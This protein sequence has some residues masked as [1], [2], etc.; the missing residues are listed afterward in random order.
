MATRWGVQRQVCLAYSQAWWWESHCLGLHECCR[1]WELQFIEGTMNANMYCDVL[2]QSMIPSLQRLCRRAVFQHDNDPKHTSKMTTTLLKKLR[3]KVILK[4]KV[5][6]RKV[7]SIH[8]LSDVV[9]EEWKRTPVVT[10]ETLVNSMPKRVKA[11]LGN[12]GGHTKY[13]HFGPN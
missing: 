13:W 7:S 5:E 10:C 11:V 1:H 2:K 9:M 3:V 8:R 6:E 12:N 4:R